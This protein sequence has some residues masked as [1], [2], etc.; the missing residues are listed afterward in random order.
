MELIQQRKVYELASNLKIKYFHFVCGSYECA[1]LKRTKY[2]VNRLMFV[3]E[4]VGGEKN[5]IEDD[6]E[7]FT[8]QA[9]H[10][11]LV[12]A[13]HSALYILDSSVRFISIHFR[14]EYF[15]AS[16]IVSLIKRNVA[17]EDAENTRLLAQ[18]FANE[19][20]LYQAILLNKVVHQV[21][22]RCLGNKI[23]ALAEIEAKFS[24]WREVIEYMNKHCTATTGVSDMAQAIGMS[25]G[26]FTRKFTRETEVSPKKFF[27]RILA[28]R[29]AELLL[30]SRLYVYEISKQLKFSSEYAFSRFFKGHFG[31]APHEYRKQSRF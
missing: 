17:M 25:R 27:N 8:L 11:Y 24:P 3:L 28:Q 20:E 15:G 18:H 30:E 1:S 6:H 16:D 5:Y 21:V 31:I 22:G 23:A 7:R 12:P 19:S 10:Y 13:F 14:L 9:G 4:N 26:A 2:N 29:A